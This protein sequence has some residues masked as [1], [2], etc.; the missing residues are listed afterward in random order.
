MSAQPATA[1]LSSQLFAGVKVLAVARIVASPFCA[2]HL[3][4]NGA[5]VITIESPEEGDS[6][7][8]S[9]TRDEF[10]G[11]AR[12]FLSFNLNKRSLTLAIN[13]PEGQEI[14]KAL[15][16]DADVV[17]ENLRTG[18][19]AK[20]G[21]AY[22]DLKKINP[23]IIFC[24]I[25]GYG[26]TGPRARDPGLDDAIQAASGM[27]SVTG[28][29]ESGPL[30]TGG[31]V[32]DYTSGYVAAFTIAGALYQRSRT[33]RG[34]AIDISMLEVAMTLITNEVTRAASNGDNP[35]LVGNGTNRGRYITNSFRCKEGHIMI[36]ARAPNL[37]ERLYRAIDRMD[38]LEDLR[39]ATPELCRENIKE[40]DAEV[41]KAILTRTAEEWESYL[42]ENGVAAMRI[43]TVQEAVKNPQIEAR[44]FLHRFEAD[45]S[46]NLP[47]YSVP[48]APYRL[49][50]SPTKVQ[51]RAPLHGE[52]T[53]EVLASIGLSKEK[54]EN[55]RSRKII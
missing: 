40:L 33:G 2:M 28:T 15:A 34:Q 50:E 24:S 48:S 54:I 11:M 22:K 12:G 47:P 55:L 51:K 46:A 42:N 37:R 6:Q 32:V 25:T 41:Q 16:R 4:L 1:A 38:I 43:L 17:I 19:M 8:Y 31:T 20:Y 23:G 36:V 49:S 52:Q 39:F 9:E 10:M 29:A 5:D 26:Q 18:S 13:T 3:A 45:L 53:N 27:M 44:Q 7:R 30:K 21:L 35:P 14:F